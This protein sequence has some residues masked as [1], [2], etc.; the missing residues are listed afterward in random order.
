MLFVN[1]K[2]HNKNTDT[3]EN[4]IIS[5]ETENE[6]FHEFYTFMSV[7]AYGWDQ[8]YDYV[9][10]SAEGDDGKIFKSDIDDRRSSKTI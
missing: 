9:A 1:Q 5:R 10:C 3:W 8:K 2:K 7:Y 6:A 4:N